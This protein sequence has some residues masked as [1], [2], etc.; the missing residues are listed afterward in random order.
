M[1]DKFQLQLQLVLAFALVSVGAM[2]LILR[3]FPCLDVKLGETF[4]FCFGI[5]VFMF[6]AGIDVAS[7]YD[8]AKSVLSVA[9]SFLG[10]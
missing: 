1:W 5:V 10:S 3:W 6:S 7:L 2:W 4:T 8:C 9:S